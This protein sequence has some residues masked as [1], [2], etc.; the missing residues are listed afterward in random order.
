MTIQAIQLAQAQLETGFGNSTGLNKTVSDH[1][2]TAFSNML[3]G[4]SPNSVAM[5][6]ET[7]INTIKKLD[8]VTSVSLNL[9]GEKIGTLQDPSTLFRFQKQ[10]SKNN[11]TYEL[12]ASIAGKTSQGIKQLVTGQ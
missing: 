11:V 3:F 4:A 10:L 12:A 8:Q 2:A 5:P 6:E 7:G 1:V 9:D